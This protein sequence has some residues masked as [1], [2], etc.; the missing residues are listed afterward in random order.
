[1]I[2]VGDRLPEATLYRRSEAGLESLAVTAL[3]AGRRVVLFAV[4][5]AFTPTCSEAHLPGFVA[6]S[7]ALRAQGVAEIIGLAVNDPFVMKAWGEA[8]NV[9]GAVTLLSD[10]NGEF[11]QALG[12]T[13]D[14]R[15]GAMGLRSMRYAMIVDDGVVRWLGVDESGLRNSSADAVQAALPGLS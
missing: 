8:Q 2:A 9:A 5:G 13:R 12:L 4:P 3:C 14:M 11:T 7:D 15:G 10:G 6:A 1:M